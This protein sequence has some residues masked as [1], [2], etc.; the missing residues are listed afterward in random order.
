MATVKVSQGILKGGKSLTEN[1]FEYYEFL[2]VPYAKPPIGELRF[3]S[4]Q[5]P[6]S[7]INER[8]ATKTNSN[9]ISYQGDFAGSAGIIGSE[10][11]LYLNVYTPHLPT[12]ELA[13]LPVIVFIHGGGFIVG[14]GT[15]KGENGPEYLIEQKT[16]VVT[17]NYRLGV[18]GF[19]S[20]DL[21][22][23][24]GNMGL[25]DQV[26]ALQWVRENIGQFGGD[27]NN[28]TI[29][30][31]SA[32]SAS[33]EY[34]I[35]S[36][37]AKGLFHKA[38]L[39]SGTAINHWAMNFQPLDLAR[40]LLKILD[41]KGS[42]NDKK[43][44]H[45]FLLTIPASNLTSAGSQ[46]TAKFSSKRIVCGFVP[47]VEKDYGNGDAFLTS[48]PYKLLKEGN[49][50]R[51]PI[52]RGFCN[53]EGALTGIM[54]PIAKKSL[55]ETKQ[56]IDCY[57]FDIESNERPQ[58]N[59]K[60]SSA[61]LEDTKSN[62][63]IEDFFGDFDFIAG[64]WI[65]AK[66]SSINVPV[67]LYEFEHAGKINGLKKLFG[68]SLDEPG[69]MHG[70]DITYVLKHEAAEGADETDVLVRQRLVT[71][72]SNFAKLGIPVPSSSDLIP[73]N[74]PPFTAESK[75]YLSI[76]KDLQIKT[77]YKP[78]KIAIFEELYAKSFGN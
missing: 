13:P 63:E 10:D 21:P 68:L 6:E 2:G 26:K 54:N 40:E 20:L 47:T 46:A 37:T 33:V 60:L 67:Y 55:I 39:Q 8:D 42:L 18:L 73:V 61:Y 75:V 9:N 34:L 72:F 44:M 71:M 48:I 62:D 30:G 56:F 51:V 78:K 7:W 53:R 65:A 69:A 70:D 66:F 23:A 50:N 64:V 45:E 1:G 4:P 16:I 35:L 24:A 5:P 59:S 76:G 3:K 15:I 32:G 41:Y 19:L 49:F 11:C 17:I 25:K 31:L 28:V 58:Y 12:P 77:D 38:I 22:E 36:P 27:K 43:A 29:M 52:I 57:P 14:N 74:W